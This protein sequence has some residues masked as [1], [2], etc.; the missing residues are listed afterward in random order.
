MRIAPFLILL[1]VSGTITAATADPGPAERRIEKDTVQLENQTLS[2]TWR[3]GSTGVE[4]T[5]LE[6]KRT[7][8]RVAP[9]APAFLLMTQGATGPAAVEW[10]SVAPPR[11]VALTP[12]SGSSRRADQLAGSG[13][14][15]ELRSRDGLSCLWR[16]ELRNGS[17]Y[18]RQRV[19]LQAMEGDVDLER[20][21]LMDAEIPQ[22]EVSGS[23][24]GSPIVTRD[25]FVGFEHPM[26]Q[27]RVERGRADAWIARALPLRKGQSVA[28]SGVIGVAPRGQMRR[29]FLAYVERERAHPYRPFLHYNSWY[30]LG[31]FTQFDEAQCLDVIRAYGRELVEKRGV[32]VDS[33]LFD[34]GW[35]KYESMWEFHKGFPNG[36]LPLKA[37]AAKIG[38]A[39]GVWLSPWGG[40]GDP[41]KRRLAHGKANG[42]EVDDQGYALSGPKYYARFHDVTLEFVTQS[43]INHFKFDGTGSPDKMCPGS[44][45]DSDFEAAIQLIADLRAAKPDL[46]I[47]LTTGT[48]PSPFWLRHADSTWRGGSDHSFTG[49]GSDRQRWI[50]YRD[51]D[52]YSGVV[53]RA[54]LYPLNSL[55]LHGI[56]HAP[57]AHKL[58]TDP[59]GDFRAEVRSYFGSGTQLQE[60]YISPSL[61]TREN[62]DDLAASARWARDN[63]DV[64]VDSHWVG[65]DPG[66]LDVYGWAAWSPRKG[67]LVLRNPSDRPQAYSVDPRLVFELPDDASKTFVAIDP[68]APG[69]D[70]PGSEFPEGRSRVMDLAAFEVRV[71]EFSV[72]GK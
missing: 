62:W 58:S 51:A 59:G 6:N 71:L 37:E 13:V 29:A 21:V 56:I 68:Y 44:A 17:H 32:R 57:H 52:T 72:K 49:V 8:S 45:F 22:A 26:S 19:T 48:W 10:K 14:E 24:P 43:G 9:S 23:C 54:P 40:Y 33:F 12:E 15:V 66:K 27:S 34:D 2:V 53:R 38:S 36:F 11:V 16:A 4:W 70:K 67:I 41:R 64:L 20:V 42:F 69:S 39:P 30:D 50:T 60:L 46:F 25:L 3:V 7:G 47:N 18:V 1:M 35:D 63:A 31:M 55:M 5:Q 28:Y 65:G 61:L